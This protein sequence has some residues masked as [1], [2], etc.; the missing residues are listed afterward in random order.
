MTYLLAVAAGPIAY[1]SAL[2][3]TNI[4]MGSILGILIFKEALTKPKIASF[5][6]IIAGAALL[7][8]G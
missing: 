3:S 5:L 6:L 4:L 8:L 1:V 2:R 7:A